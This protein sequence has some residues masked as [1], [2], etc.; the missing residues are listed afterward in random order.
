MTQAGRPKPVDDLCELPRGGADVRAL[1]SSSSSVSRGTPVI[2]STAAP[3]AGGRNE[4]SFGV[5]E[6]KVIAWH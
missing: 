6:V 2:T 4:Q 5:V 1:K 3:W